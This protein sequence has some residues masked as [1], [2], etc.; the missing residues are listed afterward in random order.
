MNAS[1]VSVVV[2]L[3]IGAMA[4]GV[5]ELVRFIAPKMGLSGGSAS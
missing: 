5:A 3:I 1:L 2:I 4:W